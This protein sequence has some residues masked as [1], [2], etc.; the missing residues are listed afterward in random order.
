MSVVSFESMTREQVQTTLENQRRAVQDFLIHL[1]SRHT[2]ARRESKEAL[3]VLDRVTPGKSVEELRSLAAAVE[4]RLAVALFY[5]VNQPVR[6]RS[7]DL[8]GRADRRRS[9]RV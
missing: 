5:T 8:R 1:P 9:G 4:R 2:M 7:S 6:H 3:K